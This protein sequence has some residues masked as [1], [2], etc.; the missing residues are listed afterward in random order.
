MSPR[1]SG[2]SLRRHILPG[3]FVA[4]LFVTLWQ[5]TPDPDGPGSELLSFMGQSMGTTFS[6][7]LIKMDKA[8]Q[9]DGVAAAVACSLRGFLRATVAVVILRFSIFWMN[10]K[11]LSNF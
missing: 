4:L 11:I 7:K 2:P 3:L 5:R 6:V 10:Q 9:G 1:R 8:D